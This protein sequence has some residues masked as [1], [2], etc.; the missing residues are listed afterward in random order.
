MGEDFP[1]RMLCVLLLVTAFYSVY[2][3]RRNAVIMVLSSDMRNASYALNYNILLP[4][5][6]QD[7]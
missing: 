2:N 5:L 4:V 7:L 6:P 3:P 1:A